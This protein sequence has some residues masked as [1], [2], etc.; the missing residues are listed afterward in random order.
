MDHQRGTVVVHI[1]RRAR[2]DQSDGFDR[3]L[4]QIYSSWP[5]PWLVA[6]H[7][8][9]ATTSVGLTVA[10]RPG[11]MAPPGVTAISRTRR[12]GTPAPRSISRF[13]YVRLPQTN[14][15]TTKAS[16]SR[17]RTLGPG[18][19]P[20]S[21]RSHHT[22]F[23]RAAHFGGGISPRNKAMEAILRAPSRFRPGSAP[24]LGRVPTP[25]E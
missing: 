7:A 19:N 10:H 21:N 25:W 5:D 11:V 3:S 8:A 22:R 15:S 17:S 2:N 9:A 13:S 18:L 24:N 6:A 4:V 14:H 20:P 16:G 1:A 12:S 23:S